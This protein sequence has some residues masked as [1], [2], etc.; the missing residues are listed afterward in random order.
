MEIC[1]VSSKTSKMQQIAHY[2][3]GWSTKRDQRCQHVFGSKVLRTKGRLW[4]RT[5][6]G[7]FKV[8]IKKKFKIFLSIVSFLTLAICFK[9]TF[10]NKTQQQMLFFQQSMFTTN[11]KQEAWRGLWKCQWIHHSPLSRL[12]HEVSRKQIPK[13]SPCQNFHLL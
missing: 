2:T 6:L 13:G 9:N 4:T 8:V 1:F 5:F 11:P 12:W 7:C 3:L 10:L